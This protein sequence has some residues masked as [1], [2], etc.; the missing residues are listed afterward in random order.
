M[1]DNESILYVQTGDI[2]ERQY[3]PLVLAQIARAMDIDAKV[4]FLGQSLKILASGEAEKIKVGSFPNVADMINK[5]LE[6]RI[7]IYVCEASKKRLGWDNVKL[8]DGVKVVGAA[9]LYDLVLEAEKTR[10]F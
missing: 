8:I 7:P 5:T 2:P 6:M 9:T 10:W 4:Y 1:Y 3:S